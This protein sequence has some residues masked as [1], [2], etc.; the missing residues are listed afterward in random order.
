MNELKGGIAREEFIRAY[1]LKDAL[2]SKDMKYICRTQVSKEEGFQIR[3]PTKH[4]TSVIA[5]TVAITNPEFAVQ[6]ITNDWR[7][8]RWYSKKTK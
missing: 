2:E 1:E 5:I 3:V 7:D 4:Y 6:S 8:G